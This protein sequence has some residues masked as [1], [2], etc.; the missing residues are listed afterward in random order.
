MSIYTHFIFYISELSFQYEMNSSFGKILIEISKQK[1]L[2]TLWRSSQ[3][4][5]A[6]SE[7]R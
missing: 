6:A 1:S 4:D 2:L 3:G 7:D 5:S